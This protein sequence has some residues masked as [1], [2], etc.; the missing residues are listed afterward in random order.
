MRRR[1]PWR[2]RAY[3]PTLPGTVGRVRAFRSERA[4]VKWCATVAAIGLCAEVWRI[5]ELPAVES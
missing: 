1:R 5:D 3:L 2:A 4:A